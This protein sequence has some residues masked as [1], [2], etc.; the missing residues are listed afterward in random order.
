MWRTEI[1][2]GDL[3]IGPFFGY[4]YA[5]GCSV[6]MDIYLFIYIFSHSHMCVTASH[7]R[8]YRIFS[9]RIESNRINFEQQLF[10]QG[11]E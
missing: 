10:E 7:N 9:C 5:F 4:K 6:P 8:I 2:C 11:A 3:A 1:M